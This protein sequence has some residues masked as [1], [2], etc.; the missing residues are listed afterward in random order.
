[1]PDFTVVP[2]SDRP[3]PLTTQQS[4]AISCLAT[5]LL[6]DREQLMATPTYAALRRRLA[7][8]LHDAAARVLGEGA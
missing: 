2:D 5:D 3:A 6:R 1:M 8:A 4:F 7:A